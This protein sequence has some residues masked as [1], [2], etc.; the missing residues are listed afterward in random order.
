MQ[1]AVYETKVIRGRRLELNRPY[2]LRSL[3]DKTPSI[4]VY[5][6][7]HHIDL[8]PVRPYQA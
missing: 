4:D 7:A 6:I 5:S 2:L 3:D 1:G 8:S